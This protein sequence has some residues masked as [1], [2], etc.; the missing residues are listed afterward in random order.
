MKKISVFL[1]AGLILT[2]I[3]GCQMSK[4][5]Y[6][7]QMTDI[8]EEVKVELARAS[9]NRPNANDAEANKKI[10]KAL[11]ASKEKIEAITP[12]EDLFAGHSN[13]VEFLNYFVAFKQKE[14][15]VDNATDK[16]PQNTKEYEEAASAYAQATK[17]ISF[18][19]SE[20]R[21]SFKELIEENRPKTGPA[22]IPPGMGIPSLMER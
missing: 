5:A 4:S 22:S 15:G 3:T 21:G 1:I 9:G 12:P 20:I 2:A 17:E 16:Q 13:L 10:I 14:L 6:E 7:Q 19:A 18:L 11:T 8:L